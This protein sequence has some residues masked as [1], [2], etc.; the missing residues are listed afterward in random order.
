[1]KT[2]FCISKLK[3]KPGLVSLNLTLKYTGCDFCF[4]LFVFQYSCI[5]VILIPL[6]GS[7]I[8]GQH[9]I[10]C[11]IVYIKGKSESNFPRL[12]KITE[13]SFCCCCCFIVFFFL[14]SFVSFYQFYVMGNGTISYMY[15]NFKGWKMIQ[16]NYSVQR[17][18][19]H[20][21]ANHWSL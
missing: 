11:Q 5:I 4:D 19:K 15:V 1:M 10:R 8:L 3:G 17:I 12:K 9:I 16:E 7:D 14:C 2:W 21:I 6:E 20:N 18:W 13:F